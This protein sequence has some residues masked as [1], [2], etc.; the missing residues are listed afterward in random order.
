[1]APFNFSL[2]SAV[3]AAIGLAACGSSSPG[4]Q[5][6]I[7]TPGTQPIISTQID[8]YVI[9][10]AAR[11]L[12]GAVVSVVQPGATPMTT[13]DSTGYFSFTGTFSGLVTVRAS[14]A[15]FV[16]ATKSLD[17]QSLSN[18]SPTR[19][20]LMLQSLTDVLLETGDYT[21]TFTADPV[22]TGIPS[23]LR[24]RTYA[25]TVTK[26]PASASLPWSYDVQVS[27]LVSPREWFGIIVVGNYL[28]TIDDSYPTLTEWISPGVYLSI[29]FTASTLAESSPVS[30]MAFV[31]R[32]TL[33]Y[34]SSRCDGLDNRF[35]LIRR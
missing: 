6:V 13:S 16:E 9:D 22:C 34:A 21:L 30:A 24:T 20:N 33:E 27:G 23:E 26:V 35:T 4:T 5:P 31:F 7:S 12:A 25:A 28:E 3:C 11:P 15:G 18:S 29:D 8:G 17:L 10:K 14:V 1:M 32:G 2:A 19:I